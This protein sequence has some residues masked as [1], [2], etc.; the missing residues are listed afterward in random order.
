MIRW[1]DEVSGFGCEPNGIGLA[2]R[3]DENGRKSDPEWTKA[4]CIKAI[5]CLV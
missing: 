1:R 3:E 5:R 2:A 4:D